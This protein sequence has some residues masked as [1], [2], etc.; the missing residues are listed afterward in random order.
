MFKVMLREWRRLLSRPIYLFCIFIV[1]LVSAVMLTSLMGEGLPTDM[2]VGLVDMDNTTTT[3]NIARNLDAFQNTRIA[4]KF[5]DVTEARHAMQRGEIYAFY[6]FPKGT[7]EKLLRQ[8]QPKVSFYTNNTY[9]MAGSLL[10]KDM[11]TMS[12]LASGAATRSVL[13][14]KGAT[15][16]QAMAFLQPV[17]VD[18]HPIGNPSLNYNVYLSNIL[19]PGMLSLMI[20]FVTVFSIGQEIKESHGRAMLVHTRGVAWK[21][22]YGKLIAQA[23]L[24]LPVAWALGAYLYGYLHFPCQCGWLTM[25]GVLSLFVFAS[26]G[27][28]VLMICALPNPRFGLSFASLWGVLSFS[29]CGMSFPA[30]AIHPMLHGVSYLFP[31]RHYYLLYVNCALDGWS[32]SSAWQFWG[33]LI[34]FALLPLLFST[35]FK[36]I[37]TKIQYMP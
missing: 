5:A 21:A 35:R 7:T 25:L 18:A 14:A 9:L 36:T 1:P 19:I 11:R 4:Y 17:A 22:L 24:L 33:A 29:I 10:Y 28:G 27:M 23:A 20:F 3:R 2:P 12:E 32:L 37:I 13:L 31:L 6:Y 8:E 26:Q 34:A 30:M 15:N 16:D